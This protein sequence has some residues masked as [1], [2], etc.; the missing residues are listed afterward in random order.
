MESHF[1]PVV[2]RQR[3]F[4]L[5]ELLVVLA[6]ITIITTITLL[7]Q[8]SFNRTT[9]L[10]STAYTVALSIRE[11]QSLGLS[12]RLNGTVQNAGYGINFQNTLPT[13]YRIY[14]DVDGST[15]VPSWC[16]K[17]AVGTPEEKPGNCLY[18]RSET[19]TTYNLNKGFTISDACGLTQAGTKYCL[20]S[21]MK[22]LDIVFLRPN[23]ETIITAT[24][25]GGTD[26]DPGANLFQLSCAVIWIKP[27]SASTDKKCVV[28]SQVGQVSVPQTCPLSTFT[29][30]P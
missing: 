18:K 7:S 30:C 24:K 1:S 11:A 6:I 17:G 13:S 5:V 14:V 29:T 21:N 22:N 27:P 12:S 19:M 28:V 10:T 2:V 20:S 23:T 9:L 3:G 8:T 16:P 4:T 15:P 26:G 25:T